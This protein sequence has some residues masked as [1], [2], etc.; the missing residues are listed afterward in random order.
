MFSNARTRIYALLFVPLLA[1][2]CGL[3]IGEPPPQ[4]PAPSYSGRGLSCVGEIPINVENYIFDRMSEGEISIFVSCLQKAFTSFAQ[5]TRG[6]K[7]S[8]AYSPEEIR[9][10]L[11]EYF[12]KQ[13]KI[14]NR[15]L[16]EFMVLKQVLVGGELDR[17]TRN[18]LY[19]AID[20]LEDIRSEAIRLKPHLRYLTPKL[21]KEN[22]SSEVGRRLA[23]ANEGLKRFIQ[24]ISVRLQKSKKS[25]PLENLSAFLYEFRQF[26]K[27][28]QHFQNSHEV[29]DWINFLRIFKRLTVGESK[30][31]AIQPTEW[32][33]L[34]QSI[35]RWYLTYL[36]FESVVKK[37]PLLH[38]VGLQNLLYFAQELFAQVEDA[39]NR[40][41]LRTITYDQLKTLVLATKALNWLP[42]NVRPT[43]VDQVL[44]AMIS[45][46]FG[47]TRVPPSKRSAKGLTSA[48][49]ALIRHEFYRWAS[50]QIILDS[51]YR[52]H[53]APRSDLPQL[54]SPMGISQEL[55]T[56]INELQ[57]SDWDNFIE[58]RKFM[59]PL[60]PE[61]QSR[62][63][64]ASRSQRVAL[65]VRHEFQNLSMMNLL[66]SLASV[67]LRGYSEDDTLRR[68]WRAGIRSSELQRFYQDFRELGIDLKAVDRR[69]HNTGARAFIEGN[70][71]TYSSD[72]FVDG[73]DNE[74]SQLT[75]PEMMEF[76]A[77]LYSG[78]EM[79]QEIYESLA[80]VCGKGPLDLQCRG[81]IS[82]SCAREHLPSVIDEFVGHMPGLREYLSKL[83]LAARNEYIWNLLDMAFT[84]NSHKDWVENSEFAVLSVILQ[85]AETVFTRFDVNED[86]FLTNPELFQAVP[87]FEGF[88]KK[89]A[90]EKMGI[91]LTDWMAK[92]AFIGLLVEKKIPG[93]GGLFV[94][95]RFDFWILK[96]PIDLNQSIKLDR[97]DLSLV[98][99]AILSKLFDGEKPYASNELIVCPT[100]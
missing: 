13:H 60:F 74:K 19:L 67:I 98:F 92:G 79:G 66:R 54:Q 47:D 56:R 29:S 25:Y 76:F 80:R 94:D 70:L 43:S 35:S 57:G 88:I 14:S 39:I 40:Q 71:F 26:V 24:T 27:W 5:L 91:R 53:A 28:D 20:F 58:L 65:G 11:E 23:D 49:L 22:A 41:P 17:I 87:V 93:V 86:G 38:G 52:G 46:V 12:L 21:L 62:V 8:A 1:L 4:P 44:G 69:N 83:P 10:F 59:L 90:R 32:M 16:G 3:K 34:L 96:N 55:R 48:S 64:L 6:R 2:S 42:A 18:E 75:M 78:G 36:Q 63:I 84:P 9:E 68:G 7:D 51:Q 73:V 82:R 37:Q 100:Q 95:L 97:K 45:R 72:G 89:F 85:Y 99:K 61:A 33:S 81:K 50:I 31:D 77:F 15:L 30:E